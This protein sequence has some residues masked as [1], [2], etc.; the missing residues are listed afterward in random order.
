M[1]HRPP[2]K[3]KKH[4][5]VRLDSEEIARIDALL[6]RLSEPWRKATRS[7]ALRAALLR[8]LEL[9]EQETPPVQDEQAQDEEAP[10]S[11]ARRRQAG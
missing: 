11:S 6:P 7:D 10:T 9:L 4:V 3:P 8:G 2:K 1:S 5:A